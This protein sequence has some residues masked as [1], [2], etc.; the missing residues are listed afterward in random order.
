MGAYLRLYLAE[1][2][3]LQRLIF[4]VVAKNQNNDFEYFVEHYMSC[5]YRELMDIG[6]TRVINMTYDE[7]LSYLNKLSP[8]LFR[9]GKPNI[10]YLQAGWIGEMYNELQFILKIPSSEIYKKLDL[11]TMK[12]FFRTLH[13][14]DKEIAIE[15]ILNN[16]N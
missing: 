6:A 2:S 13:T 14:V 3:D 12:K 16:F 4:T 5:M 1:A 11:K 10:D 9:K 8:S 7:Y 15:K